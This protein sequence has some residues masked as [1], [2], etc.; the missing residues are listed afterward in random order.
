MTDKLGVSKCTKVSP[1]IGST[2][3]K[4]VVAH[5]EVN[6]LSIW[7]TGKPFFWHD[8]IGFKNR[9]FTLGM[10]IIQKLFG[11]WA[12]VSQLRA[13]PDWGSNGIATN[14][15]R[16]KKL[17]LTFYLL[18][19][20]YVLHPDGSK[21][22]VHSQERFGPIPFLFRANYRYPA[23]I[24]SEGY[25]AKYLDMPLLGTLWEGDYKVVDQD[26]IDAKLK[27]KW[28]WAHE[29][30]SR[31]GSRS[32]LEL[33]ID[34]RDKTPTNIDEVVTKLHKYRDWYEAVRDSRAVFTHAYATITEVFEKEIQRQPFKDLDWIIALDVAFANNYFRAL[35]A[36]DLDE[37]VPEEWLVVFLKIRKNRTSVIEELVFSMISHIFYDLPLSLKEVGSRRN[38]H[39]R[40]HDYHLAND[41]LKHAID[42]IQYKVMRRYNPLLG[43]LDQLSGRKDETLTNYGIRLSRALAWYNGERLSNP[44]TESDAQKSISRSVKLSVN[45]FSKLPIFPIGFF[46]ILFRLVS[47]STRRWPGIRVL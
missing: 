46:I 33:V 10:V 4:W 36:Y 27:C 20:Q 21:V 6:S 2:T 37:D 31:V 34:K 47:R 39:S 35:D 17:G 26:N 18:K 45:Q 40:I 44:E 38:G 42:Q 23:K 24:G 43:W 14:I 3:L 29:A 41:V 11:H 22:F 19:E 28:A 7:I 1:I 32:D 15:I 16:I 8:K 13:F 12:I 25:E 9:C 30:I 5:G